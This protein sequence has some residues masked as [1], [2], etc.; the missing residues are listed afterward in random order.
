LRN[1][2]LLIELRNTPLLIELRTFLTGATLGA[3]EQL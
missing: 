3:I 2:P 1:T